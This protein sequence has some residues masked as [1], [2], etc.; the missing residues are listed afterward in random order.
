MQK[1]G[2]RDFGAIIPGAPSEG[3]NG[4]ATPPLPS[5]PLPAIEALLESS[6]GTI[7]AADVP[8]APDALGLDTQLDLLSELAA[9]ARTETPLTIGLLGP[10][11]SGKSLAMTRLIRSIEALSAA[12]A[13]RAGG[14][15]F[16]GKIVTLR[17]DAADIDGH[18]AAALAGALHASLAAEFPAFALEAAHAASDPRVAAREAFERLDAARRRLE[19]E[20][21]ALAEAE[22]RRAKLTETVLYEAS[23]SQVDAYARANRTRI[24]TALAAFGVTADPIRDYKDMVRAIADR[25]GGG[26]A[27]FA[28]RAFWAFK[29]QT[30]L[31]A[32]ALFLVL[33]GFGLGD[34][35]ADQSTW[36][37]WLRGNEQFAAA[38]TWLEQHMDWLLTLRAIAFLGAAVAVGVN[39]WRALRL[40]QLAFRGERLL[41]ADLF[42]RRRESDGHFGHQ[43][44]RVEALTSEV[45]LLARH[46]AEAERRAGGLQPANPALAEP[47]PFA[48][49]VIKQQA[50]RFIM[51]VGA[52]VQ[53]RGRPPGGHSNAAAV[54]APQRIVVAVDNIDAA[55]PSRAR[56]ILAQIRGALGPGFVTLIAAEAARL[57]NAGGED[58][59]SL[60]KWIQV[61]FQVG[62]LAGRADYSALVQDIL[63]GASASTTQ[64]PARDA[65]RSALDE[66]VSEAEATLLAELA[67]LAGRSARAVKR[68]V[69]LYRIVR[70]QMQDGQDHKG[71][72]ALM[73]ALDAG[74]TQGEIAAMHDALSGANGEISVDL[75]QGGLRLTEALAAVQAAQGKIGVAAAR[76]AAAMARLYSFNA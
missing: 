21:S 23:G 6:R 46:A 30:R 3:P 57:G 13:Q 47:P 27:G 62:E 36:L 32:T 66:P 5:A 10:S 48:V 29:G 24:K 12:A 18:P 15:P 17:I 1:S 76:R 58:E 37:G 74:G 28:L 69:N 54:E 73:L 26:R 64:G 71:A 2:L 39:V 75:H 52:L 41:Q 14:T 49:D 31:L 8:D 53:R 43:T 45:E 22:G 68:F 63:I 44:R 25:D 51:A 7:F 34:A 40:I 38:A 9:H 20:R 72:L 11:G 33:A 4:A 60:D 67:P 35:V 50:Q 56:E 65:G 59:T 70:T 61:P 19:A 55:P 16:L 42:A